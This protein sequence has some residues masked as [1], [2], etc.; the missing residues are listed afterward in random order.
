MQVLQLTGALMGKDGKAVRIGAEGLFARPTPLV[1]SG[2]G[3][4]SLIREEDVQQLRTLR[5]TDVAGQPL[6][7][8]LAL[9]RLVNSLTGRRA[10]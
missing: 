4:Q 6:V 9:R 2:F 7:W 3:A 8:E 5:R 10:G 1:A